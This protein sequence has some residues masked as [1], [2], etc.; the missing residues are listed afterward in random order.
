MAFGDLLEKVGSAGP[1]QLLCILLLTGPALPI[2]SHN[3]VQNFSAASPEHQ[4]RPLPPG[5]NASWVGNTTAAHGGLSL[6]PS[7]ERRCHLVGTHGQHPRPNGSLGKAG[8]TEP[9]QDGWYYDRST[10]SSTVV[11]AVWLI[12]PL[13]PCCWSGLRPMSDGRGEGLGLRKELRSH[14]P[15]QMLHPSAPAQ[16]WNGSPPS[17]A[18]SGDMAELL[19][20]G[21]PGG[22]GWPGLQ[23][24]GLPLAAAGHF[25]PLLHL[26]P[27]RLVSPPSPEG[28]WRG[29]GSS[30]ESRGLGA[31]TPGSYFLL[32]EGSAVQW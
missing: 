32:W 20:H 28:P 5:T 18:P 27:L 17:P 26:L 9:C 11:T 19:Q 21:R 14:P 13:L 31:R 22:A 6:V 23:H 2:A 15:A 30:G 25:H 24:P 8:E 7:P 29:V 4:C 10:F 12:A 1:F 16:V 3:L